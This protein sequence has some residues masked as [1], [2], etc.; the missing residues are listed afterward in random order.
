MKLWHELTNLK[1]PIT[2]F[3]GAL[4]ISIAAYN[5]GDNLQDAQET[6]QK[7]LDQLVKI[8]TDTAAENKKVHEAQTENLKIQSDSLT[9]IEN[10]LALL[11]L[12]VKLRR[13]LE[14]TATPPP[15]E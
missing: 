8:T 3:G 4:A 5:W 1:I 14:R 10:S 6:T 7:Q 13:E 15:V 2:V 9:S 11:A 12:E